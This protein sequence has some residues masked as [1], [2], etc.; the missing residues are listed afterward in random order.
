MDKIFAEMFSKQPDEI[1]NGAYLYHN[2][3]YAEESAVASM[4]AMGIPLEELHKR[5]EKDW[6]SLDGGFSLFWESKKFY[7]IFDS[8]DKSSLEIDMYE[9]MI[10]MRER[11]INEFLSEIAAAGKPFLEISCGS[12]LGIFPFIAK[13]NSQ[14][15]CLITDVDTHMM[16]NLRIFIDRD[17]EESNINVAAF[18]NYDI[19]IKDNSLDYIVS[20]HGISDIGSDNSENYF[21]KLT[22][23]KEKPISEVYRILKP[24]GCFVTI[25][26]NQEWVFNFRENNEVCEKQ[27]IYSNNEIEK[28]QSEVKAPSWREQFVA[29]GFQV[30]IEEK[31]PQKA[32]I[33]ELKHKLYCAVYN[34]KILGEW[35]NDEADEYFS[36]L[37]KNISRIEF[38]KG[39]IFYVLRKPTK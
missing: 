9:N 1:A 34:L 13:L 37:N 2:L 23:G 4:G 10:V 25:E 29:A 33:D 16:K 24:G 39:D 7:D 27:S 14:I 5:R 15:P 12:A 20:M 35:T 8:A 6:L 21:H 17:L 11:K 22:F 19:P 30:E 28:L 18:D 32:T 26:S 36:I 38:I 31:Y 3:W